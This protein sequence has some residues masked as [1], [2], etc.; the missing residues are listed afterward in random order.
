MI[1][2]ALDD[3]LFE[4]TQAAVVAGELIGSGPARTENTGV[5]RANMRTLPQWVLRLKHFRRQ[6]NPWSGRKLSRRAQ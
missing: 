6:F 1:V 3:A 4:T 5:P 2:A